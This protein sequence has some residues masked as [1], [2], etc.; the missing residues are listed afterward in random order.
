MINFLHEMKAL[1][2]QNRKVAV[3]E[4]GSWAP[5]SGQLIA[6]FLDEEMKM[7][8]IIDPSVTVNSALKND[9]ESDLDELA[10]AIAESINKKNK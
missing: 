7:M 9:K 10:D 2:V 3:I 4:N 5:T 8:N 6:D 1:N